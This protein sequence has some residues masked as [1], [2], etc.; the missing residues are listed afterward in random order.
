MPS[1]FG[2]PSRNE[3]Q[4]WN[5]LRFGTVLE[6]VVL[7]PVTRYPDFDND[8]KTENTRAAYPV[9][10]LKT[11]SSRASAAIRKMSYSSPPTP[12]ACCHRFRN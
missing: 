1:A 12:S 3:P 8:S 5:A 2:S 7:I 11:P 6:N 9:S 10:S 4:I